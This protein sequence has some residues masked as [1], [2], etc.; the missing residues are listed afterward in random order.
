MKMNV[1]KRF[2]LVAENE[3]F[4]DWIGTSFSPEMGGSS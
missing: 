1:T 3:L 4:S 2:L